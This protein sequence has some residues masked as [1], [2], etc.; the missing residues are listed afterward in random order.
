MEK[1]KE[2]DWSKLSELSASILE[3]VDITRK[4]LTLTIGEVFETNFIEEIVTEKVANEIV[5]YQDSE[6]NEGYTRAD[7]ADGILKIKFLKSA[8]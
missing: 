2:T 5:R 1:I 8:L 3:Y 6:E 7:F 4:D